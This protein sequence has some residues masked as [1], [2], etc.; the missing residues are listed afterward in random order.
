MQLGRPRNWGMSLMTSPIKIL[1]VYMGR[2]ELASRDATWCELLKTSQSLVAFWQMRCLT[3]FQRVKAVNVLLASRWFYAL[4]LTPCPDHVVQQLHALVE[5]FL[6]RG[7][8]RLMAR[9]TLT[10]NRKA[11]GLGLVDL[12]ARR[13]A[14]RPKLLQKLLDT[15]NPG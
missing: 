10:A 4:M 8:G 11:G 7:R 15:Q 2:D 3:L 14:A 12:F 9:S 5:S 6:W 13:S 1:G